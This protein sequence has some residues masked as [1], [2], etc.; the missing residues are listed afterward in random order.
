MVYWK[1]DFDEFCAFKS[2]ISNEQDYKQLII[3]IL[4]IVTS[5]L[6]SNHN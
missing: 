1:E 6:Q 3:S 5:N 2:F 4:I